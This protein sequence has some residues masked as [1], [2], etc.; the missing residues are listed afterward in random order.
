MTVFV[1]TSG[2]NVYTGTP[3]IDTIYGLSGDDTL[4]G[5]LGDDSVSGDSGNDIV[6]G[7]DGNDTVTGGR[8]NDTV[9]GGF[10]NDTVLGGDGHDILNGGT[11]DDLVVGGNGDDRFTY[12]RGDG[13]DTYVDSY[14]SP[15]ETPWISGQGLQNGYSWGG[16]DGRSIFR[17]SELVF[18]GTH[19]LKPVEY[20]V[21]SGILRINPSATIGSAGYDTIEFG[22][23]ID[24]DIDN[25]TFQTSAD[26]KDLVVGIGAA[27]TDAGRFADISDQIIL[28]GWGAA[29]TPS[30]AGSI[31]TFTFFNTGAVDVAHTR[32]LGGTDGADTLTGLVNQKNWITSGAGNDTIIGQSQDDI[33]NGNAGADILKGGI[34]ADLLL[35]GADND[36]LFGQLG[37][38]MLVGGE[39]ND[40]L[41]GGADNDRLDGGNGIDIA[42]YETSTIGVTLSLALQAEYG[43]TDAQNTFGAGFDSLAGFE[44]L[45][46]SAYADVLTGSTDNNVINGGAGNDLLTGNGGNDSLLGGAGDDRLIGGVGNDVFNGGAG[47]DTADYSAANSAVIVGLGIAAGQNTGAG[48]KDILTAIENL[49]G[50]SFGDTLTGS[51]AA[52]RIEGGAGADLIGGLAGNDVLVGGDGNDRLTGD[53]GADQLFGGAGAD[54]FRFI[55]TGDSTVNP[56]TQDIIFDFSHA[57]GDRIGLAGIDA[58]RATTGDD[59]FKLV[60]AFTGSAGQLVS[61]FDSAAGN[62]LVSGDVNGDSQADFA[63][64]V[65]SST[66]LVASDFIL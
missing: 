42:S 18:D 4:D 13:R 12:L 28:K 24:I 22:L 33:L 20:D 25:I 9:F 2:N 45:T 10:G 53:A 47:I 11:G 27:G 65:F 40:T 16:V 41:I 60:G 21:E 58:N 19:W 3:D 56:A 64:H 52:N 57:E 49:T 6:V 15:W 23:G 48:G 50:T 34:G 29:G 59:A 63:F 46:G 37:N 36:K 35:G 61:S 39:G 14:S 8:G 1:G 62:Y 7:A 38:D 44:N 32:L 55:A 17:G 26:G 31:E 66:A 30:A 5:G 43:F 51:T 54:I